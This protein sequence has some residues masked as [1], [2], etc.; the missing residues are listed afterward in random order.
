MVENVSMYVCIILVNKSSKNEKM[1]FCH[2]MIVKQQDVK[3]NTYILDNYTLL[4]HCFRDIFSS[5][6]RSK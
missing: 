5:E 3:E 6:Q 1:R 4:G 2:F